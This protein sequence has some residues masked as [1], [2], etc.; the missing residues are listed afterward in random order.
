MSEGPAFNFKFR[1]VSDGRNE[2]Y[3]VLLLDQ[4]PYTIG[5]Q[6]S[7]LQLFDPSVSRVHCHFVLEDGKVF[8]GDNGSMNGTYL[9]GQK[10][11]KKK[12]VKKGSQIQM[13]VYGVQVLETPDSLREAIEPPKSTRPE[14]IKIA[15]PANSFAS[16][17]SVVVDHLSYRFDDLKDFYLQA[18][19]YPFDFFAK[20]QFRGDPKR[21]LAFIAGSFLVGHG[22]T[23]LHIMRWSLTGATDAGLVFN[24]V[25]GTIVWVLLS[26]I[27]SVAFT[28][29]LAVLLDRLHA[30][31]DT[32]ATTPEYLRFF[33]YA[34]LLF[35]L[36]QA[37]IALTAGFA[38]LIVVLL[39]LGWCIYGM[40]RVFKP[41]PGPMAL[42]V[43]GYSIAWMMIQTQI[44]TVFK[45]MLYLP[46][47]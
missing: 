24:I 11:D 38:A 14:K 32:E 42:T 23:S 1:L 37:L 26:T 20:T 39:M 44:S 12:E 13:G 8:V 6:G 28:F 36:G 16:P 25:V 17:N 21:S 30:V 5:R 33:A 40:L 10:L 22:L 47:I 2:E 35:M 29:G 15:G 4:Q 46:K 31:L 9:E 43:I 34:S 45:P 27:M 7:G 18:I 19:F 3:E 41:Q